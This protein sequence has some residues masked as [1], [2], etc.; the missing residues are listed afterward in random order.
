MSTLDEERMQILRGTQCLRSYDSPES[1]G[2]RSH[3]D[4][5][6]LLKKINILHSTELLTQKGVASWLPS[7]FKF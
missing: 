1:A 2:Q 3:A 4:Y 5:F 7:W 6:R